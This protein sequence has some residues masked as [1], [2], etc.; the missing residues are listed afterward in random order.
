M[1][2]VDRVLQKLDRAMNET[3]L[4]MGRAMM[5][6]FAAYAML[7]L[8]TVYD[9]SYLIGALI[10]FL[11]AMTRQSLALTQVLLG[12]LFVLVLLSDQINAIVSSMS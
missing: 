4:R 10:V 8:Q 12:V 1:D 2:T 5:Y 11:L 3:S 6:S 7:W 9:G